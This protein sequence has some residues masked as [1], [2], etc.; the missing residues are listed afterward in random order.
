MLLCLILLCQSALASEKT[1]SHTKSK[2][3]Y[4]AFSYSDGMSIDISNKYGQVIFSE[5][6][7]DSVR[8]EIEIISEGDKLSV[9]ME[10]LDG[11]NINFS[12]NLH[13]INARTSLSGKE[14]VVKKTAMDIR[15]SING[16]HRYQINYKVSLPANCDLL[17]NNSFG[18][19]YLSDITGSVRL[20]VSHGNILGGT[21]IMIKHIKIKYGNLKLKSFEKGQLT[22]SYGN[23]E[24]QS[25]N[26]LYLTTM[27]SDVDIDK[28][29]EITLITKGKYIRIGEAGNIT[30]TSTMSELRIE[31]LTNK[32]NL[33]SKF[34]EIRIKEFGENFSQVSLLGS[35][36]N[37][38]F[39]NTNSIDSNFEIM[40]IGGKK[41]YYQNNV[42]I[43]SQDNIEKT[44]LYKGKLGAGGENKITIQTK[45]GAVH[46]DL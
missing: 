18:D 6:S 10:N 11:V 30:G 43:E 19:V 26:E 37:Y 45:N 46:F 44:V 21:L 5:G 4:K 32:I 1:Y 9:V 15:Q 29:N 35:T 36:T 25:C 33:S 41:F 8:F 28:V 12:N 7:T 13:Y 23:V 40:L 39:G 27:M 14:G 20:D 2:R 31:K 3:I 17:V 38:S 42:S 24:I 16:A 34:G 22:S